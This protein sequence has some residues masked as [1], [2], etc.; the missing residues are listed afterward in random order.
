VVQGYVGCSKER[1]REKED[2][3]WRSYFEVLYS[4][5]QYK[6]VSWFEAPILVDKDET[7]DSLLPA[8]VWYLLKGKGWL[9]KT[10]MVVATIEYSGLEVGWHNHGF[11][12]GFT[13]DCP[14]VWFDLGDH[15]STQQIRSLHTHQYHLQGSDVC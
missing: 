3:L 15:R 4:S 6:D 12:C 2:F 1:S 13:F 10:G 8:R 5:R 7:R 14:Q 11:H 9:H